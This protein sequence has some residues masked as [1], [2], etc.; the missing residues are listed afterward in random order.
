[1]K[2]QNLCLLLIL[3]FTLSTVNTAELTGQER[4]TLRDGTIISGELLKMRGDT[5]F[6]KTSFIDEL[7]VSKDNILSIEFS[8]DFDTGSAGYAEAQGSAK[9]M[10]IITGPE[11]ITTIRFRRSEDKEAATEANRIFFRIKADEKVIYEKIDDDIDE[12]VR[13]EGWTILKNV[14]PFGR[15][16]VAMPPGEHQISIF[17]GND[18]SDDYRKQFNS[19]STALTK[20]KKRVKLFKGGVTT[21]VLKSSQPFLSMG[22]YDLKWVE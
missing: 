11:L 20:T 12:E 3:I 8:S 15:Y 4:I 1:M 9:L 14:F 19:G 22:S 17:V 7:P 18:M 6:F 5:L 2:L 13:S 16:E 21:L 10:V